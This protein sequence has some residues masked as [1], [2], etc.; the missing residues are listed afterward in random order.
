[1]NK[2]KF[3]IW[4]R[5]VKK[6]AAE[7]LGYLFIFLITGLIYL[8]FSSYLS[9]G[10]FVQSRYSYFN[11]VLDAYFHKHLYLSSPI[12]DDLSIF[13]GKQYLYYGPSSVLFIL[14]FYLLLGIHASD[15]FYTL[16]GGITNVILFFLVLEECRKYFAIK[17]SFFSKIILIIGLALVS[18]NFY[19]SLT[20]RVWSTYQVIGGFYLLLFF[21]FFFKFLRKKNLIFFL[22][23]VIFFHLAWLS[24]YTLLFHIILFFYP[25][26]ILFR[27]SRKKF[28]AAS[29]IFLLC[30]LFFL[31]VFLGLNY[32]RFGNPFETGTRYIKGNPLNPRQQALM[33]EK[34][35][36][37][38]LHY[39]PYNFTY[40]FLHHIAVSTKKPFLQIDREGNSI[41]SVYPLVFFLPFLFQKK[42]LRKKNQI[43]FFF[44]AFC[45]TITT[46]FFLLTY[47]STGWTQFGMR[48]FFDV[49]PLL[50]LLILFVLNDIPV[51]AQSMLV[52]Y[53]VVI[54]IIGS[55]FFFSG[56]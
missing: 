46:I 23:S 44:L 36:I 17:V 52:L 19:L 45:V 7:N 43:A 25:L 2:R 56:I 31:A 39:I 8:Q 16:V 54:N 14:P 1:M 6:V 22:F 9:G 3:I 35:N 10:I 50:Y 13:H 53:G 4:C 20:G 21:Y 30:T 18:P 29:A 48:Y 27:I 33:Q 12:K 32:G 11:Y 34:N 55:S 15:V 49:T 42:H 41:F 5:K 38:S 26:T 51:F 28:I 37:F 47:I 40:Y 24:R